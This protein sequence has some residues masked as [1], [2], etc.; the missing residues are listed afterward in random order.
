MRHIL[1]GVLGNVRNP[2]QR[3]LKGSQTHGCQ[4]GKKRRKNRPSKQI[5]NNW[6][7]EDFYLTLKEKIARIRYKLKYGQLNARMTN[8]PMTF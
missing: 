8:D 4:H 6:H 7:M 5:T 2:I 1:L 3:P